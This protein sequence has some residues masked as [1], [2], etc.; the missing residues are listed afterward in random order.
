[1][2]VGD[3]NLSHAAGN[4]HRQV[5]AGIVLS[6]QHPGHSFSGACTGHPG[7]YHSGGVGG[8]PGEGEDARPVK[9][10]HH[11]FACCRYSLQKLLL[12]TRQ[13]QVAAVLAFA[14]GGAEPATV[15]PQGQD[16]QVAGLCRGDGFGKAAGVVTGDG[17]ALG[18]GHREPGGQCLLQGH[19]I[20][21]PEHFL[22]AR[23]WCTA[24]GR[25]GIV[26]LFAAGAGLLGFVGHTGEGHLSGA[27]PGGFD[28]FQVSGV[29]VAAYRVPQAAGMGTD[30]GQPGSCLQRQGSVV[31]QQYE[32]APGDL[33]GQRPLFG[34]GHVGLHGILVQIGMLKESVFKLDGE[35][36]AH[37]FIQ[38]RLVQLTAADIVR[39]LA[40]G[41][42]H[43]DFGVQPG[44]LGQ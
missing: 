17:A 4:G 29:G 26:G 8:C 19:G 15:A 43:R 24:H 14:A 41:A 40:E 38:H 42:A 34:G 28:H 16:G 44:P 21:L 13:G 5:S 1:M 9:H 35:D 32:G 39:Q 25:E 37:R 11:R 3:R 12:N 20:H 2:V 18:T 31:F 6:G 10:H 36:A 33:V 30:D 27:F 23:Q 22:H 7:L